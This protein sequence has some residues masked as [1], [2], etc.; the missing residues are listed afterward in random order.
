[1]S[2]NSIHITPYRSIARILV[3][4]IGLTFLTVYVTEFDLQAWNV[5]VALLIACF[6]V[7]LVLTFFMHLKYESL[8][9]KLFTGMVFLL[10][11]LVIVITFIDYFY[12]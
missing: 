4:L 1:M 11:F 7:F 9:F 8:I 5:T 10:L 6:K 2:D 12:R 3:L